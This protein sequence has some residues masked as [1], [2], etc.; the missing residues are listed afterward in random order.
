MRAAPVRHRHVPQQRNRRDRRP[1]HDATTRRRTTSATPRASR[2]TGSCHDD[3]SAR[4][5]TT[6]PQRRH[7][8]PVEKGT[9]ADQAAVNA[10]LGRR[11][12]KRDT[13]SD[14]TGG[15]HRLDETSTDAARATTAPSRW[16]MKTVERPRQPES[17]T[18]ATPATQRRAAAPEM[19]NGTRGEQSP[20][21]PKWPDNGTMKGAEQ[22][23]TRGRTR[24]STDAQG[25]PLQRRRA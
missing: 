15:R 16:S 2:R 25:E 4:S 22:D 19:P 11:R 8:E 7:P 1:E 9:A 17:E 20:G 12:Q 24:H 5:R 3:E 21:A 10:K 23:R 18:P 13:C 6:T 14:R